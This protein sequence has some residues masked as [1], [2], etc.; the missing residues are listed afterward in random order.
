[1][2]NF[3]KEELLKS[4]AIA[5]E[6]YPEIER[7]AEALSKRKISEIYMLGCGGAFTKFMSVKNLLHQ[8]LHIPV[9]VEDPIQFESVY[10]DSIHEDALVMMGTKTGTTEEIL[11]VAQK[12]K[13]RGISLLGFVGD[14]NSPFEVFLEYK[15]SSVCT[16][17]HIVVLD[18][19]LIKY[20]ELKG[21]DVD[22]AKFKEEMKYFG[23][24]L[25]RAIEDNLE[26]GRAHVEMAVKKDFQLWVASGNL[27]GETNCYVKYLMEEVQWKL[28]Q[29]VHAGEFFHGPLELIEPD[30]CVN[31]VISHGKTRNMDERVA[32]FV[33]SYGRDY[34]IIDMDDFKLPHVSEEY[35]EWVYPYVLN[36][37]YDQIAD[38]YK[39]ITKKNMGTRRYYRKVAY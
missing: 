10:M 37:F 18:L 1:M 32:Q 3:Q 8:Y 2:Y 27:W 38:M 17:V 4:Y 20:L 5:Y 6:Q 23:L 30:F 39:P 12:A 29:A 24:D 36:I 16:D 19:L 26:K 14:Q 28:A 25:V 33:K 7:I 11:K 9:I 15:L 34:T 22:Y 13:E 21:F 31:V 35:L